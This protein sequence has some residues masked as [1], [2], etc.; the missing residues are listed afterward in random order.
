MS[1][2]SKSVLHTS[3]YLQHADLKCAQL[4]WICEYFNLFNL[5]II[6]CESKRP[7]ESASWGKYETGS[8]IDECR[9]GGSREMRE[10]NGAPGPGFG[11][12]NLS[13]PSQSSNAFSESN[14]QVR[15]ENG[16]KFFYVSAAQR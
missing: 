7:V 11:T 15:I 2:Y 14:R 12:M 13:R 4:S 10:R 1:L 9:S 16:E 5:A 8:S 6:K 3:N